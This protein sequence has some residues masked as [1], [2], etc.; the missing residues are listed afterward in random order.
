MRTIVSFLFIAFYFCAN[1]QKI[2]I[3]GYL[4]DS[5]NGEALLYASC[6]D[7]ISS[8]A[9]TTNSMGYF[10]FE[11][12]P[13]QIIALKISHLGYFP[14]Q[15]E[16][17][18]SKDTMISICLTPKLEVLNEVNVTEFASFN[19]QDILGKISVSKSTIQSIPS[20]VGIPDLM[21]AITFLPGISGGREGYSNIFV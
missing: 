15:I 16:I 5:D 14:I 2:V 11:I 19:K 3:N 13:N 18:S 21:K 9:T 20:F 8:M 7:S 6:Y 4:K 12:S 10:S 17:V 1:S